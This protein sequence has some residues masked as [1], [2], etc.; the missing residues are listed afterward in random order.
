[1][2]NV[3]ISGGPGCGKGT[4]SDLISERFKLAHL[5]TG[6][7]LRIEIAN[8]SDL[9]REAQGYI[10]AGNLV[11]DEMIL[12][13]LAKT[14]DELP[15]THGVIFDGYP[16]NVSQAAALDKLMEE[17]GKKIDLFLDLTVPDEVMVERMLNRA[18]TSNRSD[19]TPDTCRHRVQVYHEQTA[20]VKEYYVK[21]GICTT[22]D[23]TGSIESI[24]KE[25]TKV[26]ELMM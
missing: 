17:R 16:R 13:L 21:K 19:D 10:A 22:I 6:H 20:P 25:I 8:F 11:P 7:L 2:L 14:I 3:I 24:F 4:Q 18:K 15:V 5:S 9:G 1:M 23:A 26:F 12:K